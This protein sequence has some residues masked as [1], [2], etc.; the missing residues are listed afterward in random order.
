MSKFHP[1]HLVL[2]VMGLALALS[3][4]AVPTE[5]DDNTT[6]A[7]EVVAAQ[8]KAGGTT[9]ADKAE[10]ADTKSKPEPKPEPAAP[11]YTAAEENAIASAADYL[12]Y[13]AFSRQGLIDQLKYEGF[14]ETDATFGV[15]H[16]RTNWN[17]Q[18]AASAKDYLDMTSFSRQGLIDQLVYEGFT[19]AQ[20]TYGVNQTGL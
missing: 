3:A 8:E 18:A 2:A 14:S 20:A 9:K 13:T 12:D 15:D 10:K 16:N 17:V 4:C 6:H 5:A 19:P 11:Q 7:E 1:K